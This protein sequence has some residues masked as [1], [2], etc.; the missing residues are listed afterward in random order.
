[1]AT[2][3]IENA[4]L[5]QRLR[6]AEEKLRGEVKYLKGREEK[7]RFSDII[8]ES[9]AMG[10]IFK[11]LEKVIDTRA[12]VCIE[13]ET[14]TGKEVIASAIHYQ[15]KRREK[16][17]VAQNCA[18]MPENLLESEL[19]G[20]KKGAF[21]GADHDKK[22]LF[23][24]ADGGTLFLDEIGEMTLEPAGQA[25]ARAAGG[26]DPAGR[27]HGVEVDR[28]AHHLRHQP[29]AGK[30]GREGRV[31]PGPVLSPARVSAA[32][33]ALARAARGHSAPGRAL[34]AQVHRRDEQ[35]GGRRDARGARSAGRLLVAGKHPRAGERGAAARHPV[36][37]RGVHH[38]GAAGA[39]G[40]QGRGAARAGGA[41]AQ[42]GGHLEGP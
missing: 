31:P 42:E 28:R 7:R 4:R 40:A 10:E 38:A 32:P 23:E 25:A 1:M 19:F 30:R 27:R 39:G 21:T 26:R 36:R 22:G 14:G 29:L 5:V 16:L 33:A 24:I 35:A 2:L 15:G 41:A 6:L 8:G 20:H 13:G 18:A 34:P 17:F 37:Q 9:S 11:Q 3:A 12:T